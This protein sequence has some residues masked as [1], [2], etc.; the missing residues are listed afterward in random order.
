MGR[1]A[2]GRLMGWHSH[3]PE[4]PSL[5]KPSPSFGDD[6]KIKKQRHRSSESLAIHDVVM[7]CRW[8][9][10]SLRSLARASLRSCN[11]CDLVY[12]IC[13][14]LRS[15]YGLFVTQGQRCKA[16]GLA[17]SLGHLFDEMVVAPRLQ[18]RAL[19]LRFPVLYSSHFLIQMPA[20][21]ELCS[22][23]FNLAKEEVQSNRCRDPSMAPLTGQELNCS[24]GGGAL[25]WWLGRECHLSPL[26][27]IFFPFATFWP[28]PR[29][30]S[31]HKRRRHSLLS[32]LASGPSL[33]FRPAPRDWDR[34]HVTPVPR[35]AV[36]PSPQIPLYKLC[37]R[38]GN[39]QK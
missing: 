16:F 32:S 19:L 13:C 25:L 1:V 30:R 21:F 18:K 36:A 10:W 24:C 20:F 2:C 8:L 35:S 33:H 37:I 28:H 38:R 11:S 22:F 29:V 12:G 6:T 34:G 17:T 5:E 27:L 14:G 39:S 9:L 4:A 3:G 26:F 23:F 15:S 7:Y 31:R